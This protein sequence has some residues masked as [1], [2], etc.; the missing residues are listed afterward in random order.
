MAPVG[1]GCELVGGELRIVD[2]HVDIATQLED[3]R[4][5]MGRVVDRLLMVGDVGDG[6][7]IAGHSESGGGTGVRDRSRHHVG[8]AESEL[9]IECIVER[10]CGRQLRGFDR[11]EGRGHEPAE[12]RSEAFPV[13]ARAV[14]VETGVGK[15][16]RREEGQPLDMVPVQVGDE[17]VDLARL[18]GER[19]A[20]HAE[21]GAAVENDRVGAL[22]LDRNA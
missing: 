1:L 18:I 19:L 14:D 21:P 22:R 13:L 8:V 5:H 15:L 17:H 12:R 7:V 10:D 9:A 6:H 4:C 11:E 16:Q 3:R 2:E 20:K